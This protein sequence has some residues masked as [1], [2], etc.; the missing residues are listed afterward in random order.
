MTRADSTTSR[1]DSGQSQDRDD[2]RSHLEGLVQLIPQ[3][4][5]QQP[6]STLLEVHEPLTH[7]GEVD[8]TCKQRSTGV[9]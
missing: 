9:R 4:N 5:P 6:A 7:L 3:S 1:Q 2:L 8:G